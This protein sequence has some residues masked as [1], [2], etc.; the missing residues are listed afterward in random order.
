MYCLD[1]LKGKTRKL[2]KLFESVSLN[3]FDQG[4]FRS[5][6]EERRNFC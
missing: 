3:I 5:E 4:K 1:R 6:K 2:K